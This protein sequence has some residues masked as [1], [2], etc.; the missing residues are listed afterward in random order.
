MV[1]GRE[2]VGM[3]PPIAEKMLVA[4][5]KFDQRPLDVMIPLVPRFER[6]VFKPSDR[7]LLRHLSNES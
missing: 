1:E 4:V 5:E 7:L 6:E 2:T 3:G